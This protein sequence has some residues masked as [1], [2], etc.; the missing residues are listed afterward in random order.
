MGNYDEAMAV[1]AEIQRLR[2]VLKRIIE[3]PGEDV[4]RLK[5]IAR[6]GLEKQP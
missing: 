3:T 1:S 2:A 4:K 5:A 6:E